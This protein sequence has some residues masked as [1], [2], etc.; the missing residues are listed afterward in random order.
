VTDNADPQRLG[1]VKARVPAVL[2]DVETGWAVPCAPYV[3]AGVGFYAVP[4]T[5]A[6]VWIEFE[7]GDVSRPIWVGGWWG[8]GELPTDPNNNQTTPESKILR[9]DTGLLVELDDNARTLTISDGRGANQ[10]VIDAAGG[11][12]TVKANSRVVIASAL[13][14]EGSDQARH[15]AVFGDD[16]VQYLNQVVS[17]LN[18]H[19]HPGQTAAGIP[20]SPAPP[21]PPLPPPSL[22]LLST[23]VTLE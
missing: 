21:V 2:G 6:G 23:K 10:I 15:P 19:M 13:V 7:A 16:L 20:V 22:S 8:A 11:T 14:L 17:L 4:A 9:T 18:S 5:G 3:G 12:V 1:R